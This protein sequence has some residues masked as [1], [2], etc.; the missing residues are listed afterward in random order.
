MSHFNNEHVNVVGMYFRGITKDSRLLEKIAPGVEL[1]LEREPANP[2]DKNAVAV[3]VYFNE[4]IH[5]GYTPKDLL[6]EQMRV[7]FEIC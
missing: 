1:I 2:H 3:N 4:K 5:I 7:S 6:A